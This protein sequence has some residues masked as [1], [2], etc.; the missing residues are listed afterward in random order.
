MFLGRSR[1]RQ[2]GRGGS[3][4]RVSVGSDIHG[5]YIVIGVKFHIPHT[6]VS[7]QRIATPHKV[8]V[9]EQVTLSKKCWSGARNILSLSFETP[10]R[11]TTK[12]LEGSCFQSSMV[13]VIV[14]EWVQMSP[15]PWLRHQYGARHAGH[16]SAFV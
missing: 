7:S 4:C 16:V 14:D 3:E 8:K 1:A 10:P 2:D 5:G 15:T 6:V 11:A 12:R 9:S 13:R